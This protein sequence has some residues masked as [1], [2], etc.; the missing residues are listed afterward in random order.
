[1]TMAL[2]AQVSKAPIAKATQTEGMSSAQ[3]STRAGVVAKGKS[4][5]MVIQN[6]R[7]TTGQAL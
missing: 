5:S 1:M 7:F 4:E 2:S 3:E 6:A